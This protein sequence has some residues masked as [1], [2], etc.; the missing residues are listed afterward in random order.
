MV[1]VLVT[2][3]RVQ[4]LCMTVLTARWRP[5]LEHPF[6]RSLQDTS[7]PFSSLVLSFSFSFSFYFSFSPALSRSLALSLSLSLCPVFFFLF[8]FLVFARS[9]CHLKFF[10][11]REGRK[12]NKTKERGKRGKKSEL[13]LPTRRQRR[14]RRYRRNCYVSVAWCFKL[15]K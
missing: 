8:P 9:R 12:W 5:V 10:Y 1:V 3:I 7:P 11:R 13:W 14:R 4:V 15:R 2:P 6:P